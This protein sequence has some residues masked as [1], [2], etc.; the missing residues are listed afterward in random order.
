MVHI[1]EQILHACYL[2]R[3]AVQ[4]PVRN[5]H[6]EGS[7]KLRAD[8]QLIR[9][10]LSVCPVFVRRQLDRQ[11]HSPFTL[12]FLHF[13]SPPS[14]ASLKIESLFFSAN[15]TSHLPTIQ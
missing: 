1:Q 12:F 2:A 9:V 7:V 6:V 5:R 10:F 13:F 3:V 11:K 14:P 15:P 8:L 4:P